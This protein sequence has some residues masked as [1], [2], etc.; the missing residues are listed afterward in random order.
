MV[1]YDKS[2]CHKNGLIATQDIPNRTF[3]HVT[4]VYRDWSWINITPNCLYNHSIVNENCKIKTITNEYGVKFKQMFA[5]RDI[6]EGEEIFVDY[7]KDSDLEQPQK[8]W[9]E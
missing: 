1:K 5:L 7:T 4:H 8:N 9:K 6:K 3:I 2:S